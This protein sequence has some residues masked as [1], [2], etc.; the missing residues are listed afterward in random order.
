MK[1]EGFKEPLFIKSLRSLEGKG[2][3][4][5]F[6]SLLLMPLEKLAVSSKVSPSVFSLALQVESVFLTIMVR[7]SFTQERMLFTPRINL[8]E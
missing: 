3:K 5:W 8:F 7:I 6:G 4:S 1:G 2:T